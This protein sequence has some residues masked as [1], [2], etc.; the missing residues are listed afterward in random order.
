LTTDGAGNLSFASV[1]AT[2]I[3][4][5]TSNVSIDA[6]DGP[7]TIGV[8]GST[9]NI[10]KF[11]E[12]E[13]VFSNDTHTAFT[14]DLVNKNLI[15]TGAGDISAGYG[16]GGIDLFQ[17]D[18]TTSIGVSTWSMADN[19]SANYP[20][21]QVTPGFVSTEYGDGSGP[22]MPTA[23]SHLTTKQYVDNKSYIANGTSNVSI[24]AADSAIAFAVNGLNAGKISL[25]SVAI[26]YLAGNDTQGNAS[27]AI[28]A[29]A[30]TLAQGID[31]VAIGSSAGN[32]NQGAFSIA[33][34]SLSG[35]TSQGGFSVAVG[36]NA[37]F[38]AQG[39]TA[40]AIGSDAGSETQG[41]SAVAIGQG[42][43]QTNQGISSVAIGGFAGVTDQGENSVAIGPQAGNDTQGTL[44]VAVGVNA[45][46]TGQGTTAVAIGNAA[47]TANQGLGAV[48]VG[49]GSGNDTQGV[50]AVAVGLNSGVTTQGSGAV[51]VGGGAGTNT[52]G[53]TAVA[54]GS[55]AGSDTQGEGAIAI[56]AYAGFATQGLNSIAIGV[57]TAGTAQGEN[58]IAIGQNAGGSNQGNNSVAI[59][60]FAGETNQP[61]NSIIINASGATLDGTESGLYIDPVRNDTGNTTNVVY[62][63]TTTKEVTY[64]DGY[65]NA[66]VANYLP[67]Y[68]G[69][70]DSV[71]SVGS[72][73]TVL[74]GDGSSLSQLTGANV[75]GDVAG[76]NHANVAD[77]AN[78]VAGANVS[79]NVAGASTAYALSAAVGNVSISGG[80]SGQYLQTDGSGA[81]SWADVDVA[82]VQGIGTIATIDIN[83]DSTQYLN[84][85]G[86]W[87]TVQADA[88]GTDFIA[89]ITNEL[90]P[91]A[92]PTP[93]LFAGTIHPVATQAELVSAI[94]AAVDGDVIQ[95]TADIDIT[96]TIAV[97]KAVKITGGFT[98]QTAA[99]TNAPVTMLNIT[100]AVYID[101][102]I[103]IKHRKTSNT[104]VEV[105]VSAN[106][107]GFVS[108]ARVEFME[109]GY[110]LRGSFSIGGQTVYTGALGNSHRHIGIYNI[111]APS[112][113]NGVEFDFPQEATARSNFIYISS[114]NATTE[115]WE[116]LLSV[117]NCS[118][119]MNKYCRQFFNCDSFNITNRNA[120]L[121]VTNN[122][123]ND[124]NGGILFYSAS[125]SPFDSF[126]TVAIYNNTEGTASEASYKGLMFV[127]GVG[128]ARSI[129]APTN[130]AIERN[131]SPQVFRADY[132][133]AAAGAIGYNISVFTKPSTFRVTYGAGAPVSLINGLS[134]VDI[135]NTSGNISL[136]VNGTQSATVSATGV[137]I[138]ALNVAGVTQLGAVGNVK[139]TG[140][141]S[142][143]VLTTD[144]TGNISFTSPDTT[145]IFNGTSNVAISTTNGDITVG[146][147]GQGNIVTFSS[148]GTFATT[149][150]NDDVIVTGNLTVQG[151][152]VT[153]NVTELNVE[154][155]II[156]EGRGANNTPLSAA[157]SKD[158]GLFS[159]YYDGA[160]KGA[161]I[162]I[163]TTG[164]HAGEYVLST[165]AT[166]SNNVVTTSSYGNIVVGNVI[167]NL[168]HG[169]TAVGIAGSDA[170]ITMSVDGTSNVVVVDTAGITV[171]GK[172]TVGG[173][174]ISGATLT[175]TDTATV[176]LASVLDAA[177]LA[178]EFLVKGADTTG[179]KFEVATVLLISDGAGSVDYTIYG[180]TSVGGTTGILSVSKNGAM[181]ELNVTPV[182]SNS[183][184]W[185]A[186]YRTI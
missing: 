143:Q 137:A 64:S 39:N 76:A 162:G 102:T 75:V 120:S 104:S 142:G 152:T 109:F 85:A 38:N 23:P 181:A 130:L 11:D 100:A 114:N 161:F 16:P 60:G 160:E 70:L 150:I 77:V 22:V 14:F 110:L 47:A 33:I 108:D 89:V 174:S 93:A 107:V 18:Y 136:T 172:V 180:S 34:G 139:I 168:A 53:N 159:Y 17:G 111:S 63:N 29:E 46:S 115:R 148:N 5:G 41:E 36:V 166:V 3:Q 170:D 164:A 156:T 54:I 182:S 88:S 157:D 50:A 127:D 8:G 154:D 31:S 49:S 27:V 87:A 105:A 134:S 2:S 43:G 48:A 178:V 90:A 122:T 153:V 98:I 124:L 175:T 146:A 151:N 30:G 149:T 163:M 177:G 4:N 186:Q 147:N 176:A 83:G 9:N 167:G 173:T 141:T 55:D 15:L 140:G 91:A 62:Y 79:G 158:R 121:F 35:Q 74:I 19:A 84:G 25:A 73:T 116:S 72:A 57:N 138:S 145:K 44:S 185:T 32:D 129:G 7:V 179:S 135:L 125:G 10:A 45:G 20:Y 128:T 101:D 66:D 132:A 65:G 119:P 52:Q 6:A 61:V 117:N 81:L 126:T 67:T 118:M 69:N 184:V 59:G 28:G 144:G 51:A 103:T 37:G 58:S 97:N 56:G 99:A 96:S 12:N 92:F 183:T 106:A 86:Q 26:G 24:A 94:A 42:A 169:G 40:V 131:Q 13:V 133:Q 95:L 78:S 123:F 21:T 80:T 82:N 112:E 68:T 71:S 155:P 165:D 1:D 113:I 171:N